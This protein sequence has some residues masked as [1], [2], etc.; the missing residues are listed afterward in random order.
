MA[1]GDYLYNAEV[2]ITNPEGSGGHFT[3]YEV[4]DG[5]MFGP[6]QMFPGASITCTAKI[7]QG[8]VIVNNKSK[9]LPGLTREDSSDSAPGDADG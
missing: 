6:R 8:L 4:R 5:R 7:G 3:V 1:K 9:D 2:I